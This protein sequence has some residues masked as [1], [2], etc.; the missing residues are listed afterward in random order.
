MHCTSSNNNGNSSDKNHFHFVLKRSLS[1][2]TLRQLRTPQVLHNLHGTDGCY[3]I[4][5]KLG[6]VV[7][8]VVT[9]WTRSG[10]KYTND[11]LL[12]KVNKTTNTISHCFFS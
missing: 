1:I 5:V 2:S 10:C 3:S 9:T 4:I 6:T 12:W 11:I 8:P 7:V